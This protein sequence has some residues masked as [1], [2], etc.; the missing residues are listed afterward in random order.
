MTLM[1]IGAICQLLTCIAIGTLPFIIWDLRQKDKLQEQERQSI[2]WTH[3]WWLWLWS[4]RYVG[5]RRYFQRVRSGDR[6]MSYKIGDRVIVFG[7]YHG[8]IINISSY[9]PSDMKYAID[10]DEYKADVV[11]VGDSDLE[12]EEWQNKS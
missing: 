10:L 9:R 11:F 12:E 2:T 4:H 3:G 8:V 1:I 6:G 7:K 5:Y